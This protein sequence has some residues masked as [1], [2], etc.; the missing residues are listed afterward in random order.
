VA[1]VRNR[2]EDLAANSKGRIAEMVLFNGLGQRRR[3]LSDLWNFDGPIMRADLLSRCVVE[4][5]G[6][7]DCSVAIPNIEFLVSPL[8]PQLTH[9]ALVFVRY[10]SPMPVD[11]V[12]FQLLVNPAKPGDQYAGLLRGGRIERGSVGHPRIS[13]LSGC[14]LPFSEQSDDLLRGCL[15]LHAQILFRLA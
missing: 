5:I 1:V 8:F 15:V 13:A 7:P 2:R 11:V 14:V 4:W 10:G 9:R 6:S 12:F 3:K